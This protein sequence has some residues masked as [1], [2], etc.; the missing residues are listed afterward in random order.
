MVEEITA[1]QAKLNS[2]KHASTIGLAEFETI[3]DNIKNASDDGLY[4]IS[5]RSMYDV[6]REKLEK[7]GYKVQ[8]FPFVG[9]II[10]SWE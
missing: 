2:E 9:D 10:I 6:N 5:V 3:M 7:L 4:A 1:E 8:R